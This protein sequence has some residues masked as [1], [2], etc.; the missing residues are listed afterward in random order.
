MSTS[1]ASGSTATVIGGGVHAALGFGGGN[2]LHAMHAALPLHLG[3]N[4]L[5]LDNGDHFLVA[6]H[7]GLRERQQLDLPAM[8]LG[9]AR[10]HAEHLGGKERGL[11]AARA[12]AD[13]QDHVLLVVGILGQQQ[14]LDLFF[15][16]GSRGAKRGDL[17]LGHGAHL[18]IA[19]GQHGAGFGQPLPHLLQFANFITGSSI[20]RRARPASDT[21]RGR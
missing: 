8:L 12:G 2:A 10:V 1:S 4:A 3:V 9:K 21:S 20:S 5:A 14:R 6:A 18:G 11:V 16:G 13:F 7:A 15:E 19:L 17:F